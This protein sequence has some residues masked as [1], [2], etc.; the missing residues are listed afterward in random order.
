[1]I[2]LGFAKRDVI[3]PIC[4]DSREVLVR[5]AMEGRMGRVWVPGMESPSFC[6]IRLGSFSY[7]LGVPPKGAEALDLSKVLR[8]ECR[9]SFIT[10]QNDHWINWLDQNL[11]CA[12][13]TVSR[14][15]LK[16][17]ETHFDR[18]R[19]Q[20]FVNALPDEYHL[21]KIDHYFYR[22]AL[23]EEWSADFVSNFENEKKFAEYGMGYVIT[24]GKELVSGCSAYGFS[25]GMMEVEIDTKKEY[26]RMG[27]A[28]CAASK[29]IL[30]C[31]DKGLQPNWDAANLHS[32]ALAE[33]LGY[34]QAGEYSVF[35]IGPE[36]FQ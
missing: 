23:K 17:D 16:N 7:P 21:K 19:L 33:K 20:S 22:L 1:M 29:F 13:R 6:L 3:V 9:S 26:R 14:Y 30:D 32:A 12:Y 28:S 24:K 5:S 34:I 11:N 2:E 36:D 31:L 18:N 15:A 25:E 35:Q 4:R 8:T 10:P 27:L